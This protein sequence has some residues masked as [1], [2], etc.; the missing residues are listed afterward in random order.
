M[1]YTII[2]LDDVFYNTNDEKLMEKQKGNSFFEYR[3][4]NN[5]YEISRIV[6]TNLNDFLDKNNGL[7]K[8]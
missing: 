3:K 2:S 6:S 8:I 7:R 4:I 5:K 1:L